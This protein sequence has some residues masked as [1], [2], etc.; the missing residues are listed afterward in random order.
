MIAIM[1]ASS[2]TA[3]TAQRDATSADYWA[4]ACFAPAGTP[5]ESTCLSYLLDTVR[6]H[7]AVVQGGRVKPYFCIPEQ[8]TDL[9]IK[10]AV[11]QYLTD[12]PQ[13]RQFDFSEVVTVALARQFPCAAR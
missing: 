7:T 6:T 12:N 13:Y 4:Q 11:V 8:A 1:L 10:A 3:A 9:Q 2:V 5:A